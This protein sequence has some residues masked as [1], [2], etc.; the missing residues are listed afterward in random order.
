MKRQVIILTAML[1]GF[2]AASFAQRTTHS[3]MW[4]TSGK[5]KATAVPFK[6]DA[7]ISEYLIPQEPIKWGMDVAWDNADNV[8]RGTNYIGKDVMATGRIS[9]QPSDLVDARPCGC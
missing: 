5:A 6:A 3:S 9:F 2:P 8:T 7:D 4:V 1:S